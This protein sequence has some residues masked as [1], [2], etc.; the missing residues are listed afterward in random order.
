GAG[1]GDPIGHIDRMI[2]LKGRGWWDPGEMKTHEMKFDNVQE[3]Y[4]QYERY[5][6]NVVKVLMSNE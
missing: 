5:E 3:A 2:E 6:D 1:S 4:D